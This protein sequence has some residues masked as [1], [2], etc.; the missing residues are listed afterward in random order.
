MDWI[1]C[2]LSIRPGVFW[3]RATRRVSAETGLR[4]WLSPLEGWGVV[5]AKTET[6]S[7]AVTV[8][9]FCGWPLVTTRGASGALEWAPRPGACA[10]R[11]GNGDFQDERDLGGVGPTGRNGVSG[12]V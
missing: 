4:F 9:R 2:A 1:G 12:P 8:L 3:G 6:E 11:D 10:R 7:S 5:F